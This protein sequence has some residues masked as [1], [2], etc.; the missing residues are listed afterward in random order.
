MLAEVTIFGR[1]KR[2]VLLVPSEAV[3][4]TG[5][6]NVVIVSDAPGKFRAVPVEVGMEGSGK[7]EVVGGLEAGEQVVVSGQFLLDSEANLR[8]GLSRLEGPAPKDEH[9]GHEPT[10][11]KDEHAGQRAAAPKDEH[12][13]HQRHK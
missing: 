10:A 12:A 2:E 1:P 3:I 7:T 11:A 5:R 6:R 8:T 13:E 9:A 4:R